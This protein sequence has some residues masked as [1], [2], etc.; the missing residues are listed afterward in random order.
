MFADIN[1]EDLVI[2]AEDIK[3]KITDKTKAVVVVTLGGLPVAK[4]F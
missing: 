1:K 2:S 3:R 4:E